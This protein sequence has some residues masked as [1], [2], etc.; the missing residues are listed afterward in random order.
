MAWR[1]R[2]ISFM[3]A[4]FVAREIGYNM[5]SGWMQGDTAT[6]E[7]FSP[8]ATFEERFFEKNAGAFVGGE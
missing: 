6:N 5:D 2:K 3:S 4:N 8:L 1:M 7:H